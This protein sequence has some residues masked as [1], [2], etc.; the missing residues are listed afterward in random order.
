[1][2]ARGCAH[3]RSPTSFRS[4]YERSGRGLQTLRAADVAVSYSSAVDRHLEQNG[5]TRRRLVPLF[6]TTPPSNLA[7][8]PRRVLYAGRLV[9]PKGVA[10][11]IRAAAAV[12]CELVVCGDGREREALESL[13]AELGVAQR[14]RFAGWLDGPAL[15]DEI[16]A[17]Q[18]VAIPSIWPEPFGLVGIE[19]Q[20]AGRAVVASMTGGVGD[21][22]TPEVSGVAV[23]PGDVAALQSALERLC[24]DET[25]C[26]SLGA[27]G[28]AQV[29]R[30]FTRGQH[31][32]GLLE[33]YAAAAAQRALA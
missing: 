17:A 14:T 15:A 23:E 16:A 5:I 33:A 24:A 25:L 31:V 19:A 22:L 8:T 12:D 9:A 10:T 11:L 1:M 27:A 21:W 3:G 7:S 4:M 13:A 29:E 20:A 32:A 6:C 18:V 26:Q 2:L 30:S 28:R